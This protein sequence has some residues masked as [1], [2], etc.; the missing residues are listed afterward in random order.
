MSAVT[1]PIKSVFAFS[2]TLKTQPTF[3]HLK[4]NYLLVYFK[5][6]IGL[7]IRLIDITRILIVKV[8]CQLGGSK[9]NSKH[10]EIRN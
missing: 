9:N 2:E 1:E 7:Y 8:L 6:Y 10:Y 3:Q 5:L 4:E